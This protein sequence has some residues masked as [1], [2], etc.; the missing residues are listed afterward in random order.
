[1]VLASPPWQCTGLCVAR[2]QGAQKETMRTLQKTSEHRPG[3]NLH[4]NTTAE[5]I[6]LGSA[7]PL[8]VDESEVGIGGVLQDAKSA[9][10][11]W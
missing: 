2:G 9:I 3:W 8:V 11:E 1:M 10:A 6:L 5:H 4:R 7:V